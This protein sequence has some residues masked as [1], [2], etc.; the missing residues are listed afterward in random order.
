MCKKPNILKKAALVVINITNH[1]K[2]IHYTV[3]CNS[4]FFTMYRTF[5]IYIPYPFDK[6]DWLNVFMYL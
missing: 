6:D 3:K 1:H 4:H 2:M 5:T